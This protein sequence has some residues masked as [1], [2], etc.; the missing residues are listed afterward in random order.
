MKT[1][2]ITIS[3][4]FGSGGRTIGKLIAKELGWKFYDKELVDKISEESNFAKDF[5]EKR[6]EY[7]STK[8][9]FMYSLLENF[10]TTN[11]GQSINDKLYI[12]QANIIKEIAE[13]GNCVIV[14]RCANYILRKRDDVFNVFIH[15]DT[16]FKSE[17]I[18]RLYGETEKTAEI[19]LKDKDARRAVYYKYYTGEKWGLISNY[20]ISFNSGKIGINN[21][22]DIIAKIIKNK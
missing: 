16:D 18:V 9:E 3:R 6:G 17:R 12:T 13:E 8:S 5:I 15:A 22:V 21:C 20:D 7:A 11:G 14:G 4:E 19:R 10:G 1:K 2:V